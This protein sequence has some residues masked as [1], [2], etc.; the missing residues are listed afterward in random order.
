MILRTLVTAGQSVPCRL[1]ALSLKKFGV[2][3]GGPFDHESSRLANALV[4]N[5]DVAIVLE[6]ASCTV[7]VSCDI[8]FSI[9]FVGG[10]HTAI[11]SNSEFEP[12]QSVNVRNGEQLQIRPT[13]DGFRA[14]LAVPG[15]FKSTPVKGEYAMSQDGP[16][17]VARRLS[18]K[19]ASLQVG[20]IL[21]VQ[22]VARVEAVSTAYCDRQ[23]LR[24]SSN[25]P[26]KLVQDQLSRPLVQGAIQL[27]PKGELLVH[28][29]DGPTIGGYEVIGCVA[30]AHQSR[31]AQIRPGQAVAFE[32]IDLEEARDLWRT[33]EELLSAVV[34]RIRSSVQLRRMSD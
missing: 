21:T 17:I 10:G 33:Q 18:E 34:R 16:T 9:A 5:D 13:R 7:S 30:R 12:G 11:L 28:G 23:G 1:P 15:G 29:P 14:Y 24:M 20:D 6:L 26:P 4:G 22:S 27:T 32:P 19:P 8:D 25:I 2:P 3:A 31:L